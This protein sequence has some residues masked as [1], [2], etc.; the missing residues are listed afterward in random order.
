[1]NIIEITD[2]LFLQ[3]AEKIAKPI[4]RLVGIDNFGMAT[5]L[6]VLGRLMQHWSDSLLFSKASLIPLTLISIFFDILIWNI[7]INYPKH[8]HRRHFLNSFRLQPYPTLRFLMLTLIFYSMISLWLKIYHTT[9][10]QGSLLNFAG[11]TIQQ[12]SFYLASIEPENPS[13]SI[14]KKLW[15]RFCSIIQIQPHT[16]PA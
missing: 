8:I 11:M 16:Q 7:W 2:E 1:M 6:Y 15:D 12:I 10:Y 14:L 13:D 9:E 3:F 5:I 4:Y